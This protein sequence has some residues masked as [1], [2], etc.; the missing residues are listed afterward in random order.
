MHV[1]CLAN[2]VSYSLKFVCFFCIFENIGCFNRVC[3]NSRSRIVKKEL[4]S[5]IYK[6]SFPDDI[7]IP[8]QVND[9][10]FIPC[11]AFDSK[12]IF[13]VVDFEN[14]GVIAIEVSLAEEVSRLRNVINKYHVD[15]KSPHRMSFDTLIYSIFTPH[16]GEV[17]DNLVAVSFTSVDF[18][19]LIDL[20]ALKV[21]KVSDDSK[22]EVWA[23][24]STNEIKD[25][26]MYTSR[27]KFKD[28]YKQDITL[29]ESVDLEILYYDIREDRFCI[30]DT[31][32]GIDH[33]HT[34]N[35]SPDNRYILL[36]QMTMDS[37]LGSPCLAE[38]SKER[39][40]EI[41]QAGLI[42]GNCYIYDM[43][44]KKVASMEA[45]PFSPAH[46]EFECH[47]S[48]YFYLS[49]H[50]LCVM[51][52]NNSLY[53]FGPAS[54]SKYSLTHDGIMERLLQFHDPEAVR[55]PGHVLFSY[56]G[57][58]LMVMPSPPLQ[59]FILN[60]ETMLIHKKIRLSANIKQPDFSEGPYLH[61]IPL[62]DRTPFSVHGKDESPYLYCNNTLSI[63]IYDFVADYLVC[64]FKYNPGLRIVSVG[65]SSRFD[66]IKISSDDLIPYK[67]MKNNFK[68]SNK[69]K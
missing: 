26:K 19:V 41:Q 31:I 15:C 56:E 27:W 14:K 51:G 28:M 65:H 24:S 11:M 57:K 44:E 8:C 29:N 67:E 37:I 55:I 60:R 16:Q 35:I 69:F 18:F 12:V 34:T 38:E 1:F 22:N 7:N 47:N 4:A 52:E 46:A 30:I 17:C 45:I 50:N 63:G 23:Y 59:I 32:E 20:I 42:H 64:E 9:C 6:Y 13:F 36:V 61:P 39:Q 62:R 40:R 33:I 3:L 21:Y 25:G 66:N 48:Q 49:Q 5:R 43:M 68:N 53:S 58:Q 2:I 54:V 10:I